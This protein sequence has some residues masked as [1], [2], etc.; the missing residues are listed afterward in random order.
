MTLTQAQSIPTLEQ[1]RRQKTEI[2]KI[3]AKHG[4][5]NVRVFGSVARG[6]AT[7]E[8]DIDFMSDYNPSRRTPWFPMGL[9]EEL[10]QLTGFTVDVSFPDLLERKYVGPSIQQDIVAL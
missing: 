5:S 10:E 6:E 7:A 4:C 9:I 8:S 2:L 1:L 3:F